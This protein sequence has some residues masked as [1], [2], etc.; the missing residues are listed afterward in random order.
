MPIDT[1][2]RSFFRVPFAHP[3]G[4]ELKIIGQNDMDSGTKMLPAA[5]LDLSAGGARVY[6]AAP[7]PEESSLLVELR[8]TA[9]GSV[10]R[11]FGPVVR[12]ILTAQGQYEYSIQ[13]SLDENGTAALTG[14]LNQ[15][16]VKLRKTPTLPSCS[17][18]TEEELADFGFLTLRSTR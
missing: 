5:I 18:C 13:F 8:F 15:L 7:L 1:N 11:P 14:M 17:F 2:K 4:A 6:T 10:Y 9:L 16:A 3:L 12:S